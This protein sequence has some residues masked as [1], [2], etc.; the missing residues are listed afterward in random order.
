MIFFCLSPQISS[1]IP[2]NDLFAG[3]SYQFDNLLLSNWELVNAVNVNVNNIDIA[4][5]YHGNEFGVLTENHE[6]LVS[7][8]A[9]YGNSNTKTLSF[10][11]LVHFV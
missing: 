5:G 7:Q 10:D 1:A 2:L 3:G 8:A 11:F 4:T 6:L 9:S